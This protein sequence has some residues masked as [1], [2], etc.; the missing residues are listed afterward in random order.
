ME[1]AVTRQH[2]HP[3]T[4]FHCL[5]GFYYLG[6]TRKEL[7]CIYPKTLTGTYERAQTGSG[8]RFTVAIRQWLCSY[9]EDS[10]LS[11]LDEAQ[12]TFEDTHHITISIFSVW[13]LIHECGLTR[14]V[15]ERKAMHIKEADVFRFVEE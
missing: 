11:Y 4:V 14:K 1:E 8:R 15:L 13:R 7:A 5:Y 9:F 10:P 6:Y 12:A 2:A 3:N